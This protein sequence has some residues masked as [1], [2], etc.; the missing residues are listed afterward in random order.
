MGVNNCDSDPSTTNQTYPPILLNLAHPYAT[1]N[2]FTILQHL[3]RFRTYLG[4]LSAGGENSRIARDVLVDLVDCSGVD[5]E[6]LYP[7][8]EEIVQKSKIHDS[9]SSLFRLPWHH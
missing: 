7:V 1:R 4:S 3:K 6:A 9:T 5:F 2:L 8:L